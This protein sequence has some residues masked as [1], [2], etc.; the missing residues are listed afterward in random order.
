MLINNNNKMGLEFVRFQLE[1]IIIDLSYYMQIV[2]NPNETAA[3][4]FFDINFY[5]YWKKFEMLD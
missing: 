4:N 2:D 3:L 1:Y 5:F